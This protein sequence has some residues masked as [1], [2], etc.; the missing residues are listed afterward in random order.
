MVV[1]EGGGHRYAFWTRST[2]H[3]T[4]AFDFSTE[5]GGGKAPIDGVGA[6]FI[7]QK[8]QA[9]LFDIEGTHWTVWNGSEFNDSHPVDSLGKGDL[10]F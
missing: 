8:G 5:Y 1:F 3:W 6:A 10:K 9:V 4:R 2:D 7:G